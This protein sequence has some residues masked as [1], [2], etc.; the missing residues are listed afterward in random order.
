[1]PDPTRP[2]LLRTLEEM[3]WY[4]TAEQYSALHGAAAFLEA[5]VARLQEEVAQLRSA[6]TAPLRDDLA[7]LTAA[8]A[9]LRQEVQALAVPPAKAAKAPRKPRPP[10]EK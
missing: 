3:T 5:E 4:G 7:I 2:P 1:M 6:S 8:V 10:Q 9:G